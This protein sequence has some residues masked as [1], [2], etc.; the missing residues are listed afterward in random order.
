MLG[1]EFAALFLKRRIQPL[2][3][4]GHPMWLYTGPK[5]ST[6]INV[7]DYSDKELLDE[8]V[9]STASMVADFIAQFMKIKAKNAQLREELD[10]AK[11]SAEQIETASKIAAEAWHKTKDLEKNLTHVKAKLEKERK[12]KEEARSQAEKGE[13]RPCKFAESLLLHRCAADTPMDRSNKLQVDSLTDAISFSVDSSEQVQ[14]LLVKTK[15]ALSKLYALLFPKQKQEKTLEELTEAFFMDNND[16]IEVLK[17][18]SCIYGVLLAFQF[19][20]RYGVAAEFEEQS[21]ALPVDED[22]TGVYLNP[23][24]K[25]ARTCACHLIDLVEAN[26]K[27]GS[28]KTAPSASGQT[29]MI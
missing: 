8:F 25:S 26:K 20:M 28:A 9:F 10:V 13:Y 22:G 11:S 24:T 1:T 19:M 17:R 4:R 18:T 29:I 27:K 5:D 14:G 16:P 15:V 3:A 6:S 2:M 23:F 7:A 21:K 12:Q